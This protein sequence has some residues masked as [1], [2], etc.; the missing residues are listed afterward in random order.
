M[1]KFAGIKKKF[2]KDFLSILYIFFLNFFSFYKYL[3]KFLVDVGTWGVG[4]YVHISI[5]SDEKKLNSE[6]VLSDL[7]AHFPVLF[8]ISIPNR[9]PTFFFFCCLLENFNSQKNFKFHVFS[10][11]DQH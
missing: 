3:I 2:L 9:L 1:V 11:V 4:K 10:S 8:F 6:S 7:F 5:C